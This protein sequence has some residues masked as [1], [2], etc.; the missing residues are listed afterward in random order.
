[1]LVK[2]WTFLSWV[3]CEDISRETEGTAWKSF[4]FLLSFHLCSNLGGEV[5]TVVSIPLYRWKVRDLGRER[6]HD[7]GV[8]PSSL[9]WGPLVPFPNPSSPRKVLEE[10]YTSCRQ[11]KLVQMVKVWL[12]PCPIIDPQELGGPLPSGAL[13]QE[14][15]WEPGFGVF[16]FPKDRSCDPTVWK[17]FNLSVSW[18]SS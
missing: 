11:K 17:Q 9:T 18:L 2:E 12:P 7:L 15:S 1:M 13:R 3:K 8:K 14:E 6:K 4:F 10:L 16:I 5:L